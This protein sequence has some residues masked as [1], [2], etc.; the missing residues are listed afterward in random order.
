[1]LLKTMKQLSPIALGV[2]TFFGLSTADF[3][4][5][6]Q[7]VIIAP[8]C[9]VKML[10][11]ANILAKDHE[12]SLIALSAS[13]FNKLVNNKKN[14]LKRCGGFINVTSAWQ[15][16]KTKINNMQ[17]LQQYTALSPTHLA[18]TS[19]DIKYSKETNTILNTLNPDNMWSNLSTLSS[20]PD[21]YANSK[22]G[23]AAAEWVKEQIETL[24]KQY[25][26]SDVTTYTISTGTSYKQPSVVVK[27]GNSAEPGIV[28]GAH[29]DT[30]QKMF[31]NMPGADDDGSG[32]VTVLEIA[33]TILAS[34]FHFKK[35]IYF[36]WY[37]AEEMGL[38]GSQ[39]VVAEFKK[40]HIPVD[41]VL[42]FD[43]TGYADRNDPTMWLIDDYTNKDLTS[44]LAKLIDAYVKKPVKYTT[45]GYACSDHATWNMNGYPAAIAFEAQFENY[46]PYIHSSS[47]KMQ[48]LS[49]QHMT[50]YAKLG[51]AFA[52][53][54]AE[55]QV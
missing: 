29:L 18:T 44:F 28:I 55:P 8:N 45:C 30:L 17:F 9:L 48:L 25:N 2:L 3:A 11:P 13:N 26:R 36:I 16:S 34:N 38:I 4:A 6:K 39:H 42:H 47:D 37:S 49:L 33:R 5:E 51:I 7:Q 35:P 24:A 43:M 31:N 14:Y 23:V 1:M 22:T 21:R 41:N 15:T 52:T 12:F 40:Q 54:L 20:F 27:V 46:N 10:K 32:S 50:D 53:E 19:Y